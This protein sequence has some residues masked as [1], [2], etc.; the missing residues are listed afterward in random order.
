MTD[1]VADARKVQPG[2]QKQ[3]MNK[4]DIKPRY[5]TLNIPEIIHEET[6]PDKFIR[7]AEE[8]S[9]G[10]KVG[11]VRDHINQAKSFKMYEKQTIK[12]RN[13]YNNR[14]IQTPG[15]TEGLP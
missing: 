5:R 8:A 12:K 7:Q 13:T 11:H 4:V 9:Q 10:R 3:N 2:L 6:E 15:Q 1:S 14:I